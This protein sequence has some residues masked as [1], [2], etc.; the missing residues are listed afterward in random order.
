[1]PHRSTPDSRFNKTSKKIRSI[2]Q[3]ATQLKHR[4]TGTLLV[5]L[6][7][8][9]ITLWQKKKK[10]KRVISLRSWK[11]PG[12]RNKGRRQQNAMTRSTQKENCVSEKENP[13]QVKFSVFLKITTMKTFSILLACGLFFLS[14]NNNGAGA[15]SG[16]DSGSMQR[17]SIHQVSDS[18]AADSSMTGGS[19]TAAD[20]MRASV[21]DSNREH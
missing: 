18:T 17:D 3:Y 5:P 14:C 7:L 6:L 13:F 9:T 8:L 12:T 1:M 19:I 21:A 20:S 2:T 4:D 15:G 10:N 16:A 11:I